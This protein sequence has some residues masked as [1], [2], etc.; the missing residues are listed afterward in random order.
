MGPIVS[1]AAAALRILLIDDDSDRRATLDRELKALARPL[2]L[3]TATDS[4]TARVK[5]RTHHDCVLV[6]DKLNGTGGARIIQDAVASRIATG[7]FI[8]VSSGTDD[9]AEAD[10]LAAG[11][12]DCI[13]VAELSPAVLERSIRYAIDSRRA[14]ERLSDLMLLDPLTGLPTATLFWHLAVHSVERAKRNGEPVAALSL[15]LKGVAHINESLGHDAGD[16]AIRTEARRLRGVLRGSDIVA[17]L[18]GTKL[19]VLLDTMAEPA[20]IQLVAEKLNATVAPAFDY[21]GTS[22]QLTMCAGAAI[23][24]ANAGSAEALVRKATMAMDEA[25][26]ADIPFKLA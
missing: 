18:G 4:L 10:A 19:I 21:N 13:S 16:A 15:Y 20:D 1:Q 2:V 8:L 25:L 26:A 14:S 24:P 5:L 9:K 17:R 22:V 23:Y 12:I 7:P 11:A 3:E 6:A